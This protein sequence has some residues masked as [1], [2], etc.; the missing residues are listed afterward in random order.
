MNGTVL[1]R[2][3][4]DNHPF[5]RVSGEYCLVVLGLHGNGWNAACGELEVVVLVGVSAALLMPLNY[6]C[7]SQPSTTT[8]STTA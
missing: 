2:L 5:P 6:T 7:I 3:P 4:Q 1:K 8:N